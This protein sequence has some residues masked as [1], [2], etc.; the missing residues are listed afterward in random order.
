VTRRIAV[1]I[2]AIVVPGGL[3]ALLGAWLFKAFSRTDRGQRALSFAR[4][5]V[6]AGFR[7][8]QKPHIQQAA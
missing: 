6:R 4:S 8:A 5:R 3:V 1:V 7:G 2:A